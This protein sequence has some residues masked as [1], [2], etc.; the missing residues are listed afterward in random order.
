MTLTLPNLLLI[1]ALVLSIVEFTRGG[2]RSP[3]AWAV[4]LIAIA[5]LLPLLA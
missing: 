4:F 2:Y 1:V 5:L 3:L